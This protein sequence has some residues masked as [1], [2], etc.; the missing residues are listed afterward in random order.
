VGILSNRRCDK[1]TLGPPT[2]HAAG[3]GE[4]ESDEVS[5]KSGGEKNCKIRGLRGDVSRTG[6]NRNHTSIPKE[7]GRKSS[8]T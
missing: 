5:K 8:Q 7:F 2:S 1:I 3:K 6:T 4:K